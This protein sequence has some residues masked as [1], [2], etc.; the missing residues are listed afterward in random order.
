MGCGCAK[1]IEDSPNLK[2]SEHSKHL[3]MDSVTSKSLNQ[4]I[5][6]NLQAHP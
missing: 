3:K 4:N 5:K 2:P 6:I 1:S